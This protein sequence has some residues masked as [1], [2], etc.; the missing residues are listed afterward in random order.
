M[1]HIIRFKMATSTKFDT[2]A[3]SLKIFLGDNNTL[4]KRQF[5]LH[6]IRTAWPDIAGRLAEHCQ[7][8]KIEGQRLVIVADNAP[9]TNQLFMVKLNLLQKVNA[10][11]KGEYVFLDMSFVSGSLIEF[12]NTDEKEEQS[13]VTYTFVPCPK[14]GGQ[15]ES[16]RKIC[17]DCDK[18][19]QD[20]R[21]QQLRQKLKATPWLKYA[22]INIPGLDELTFYRVKD[23]M[24]AYYF[25]RVRL[26]TATEQDQ[27]Q[28]V[29]FYTK[30]LPKEIS[31]DEYKMTL[32]I[33]AK[34]DELKELE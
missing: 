24:A 1:G 19:E 21:E 30:K 15:M 34:E 11:L 20:R 10:T 32:A 31:N 18:E 28:A 13:E 7:P 25:E 17:F 9:L 8:L 4:I 2:F 29:L 14:C 6:K 12:K 16:W 27:L 23:I 33:L 26:G 3:E 22:E 5:L